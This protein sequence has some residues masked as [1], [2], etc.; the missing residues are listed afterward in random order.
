MLNILEQ[1]RALVGIVSLTL[2]V[3]VKSRNNSM[4]MTNVCSCGWRSPNGNFCVKLLLHSH[5]DIFTKW[6]WWR[7]DVVNSAYLKTGKYY[8]G[9]N[10]SWQSNNAENVFSALFNIYKEGYERQIKTLSD[11]IMHKPRRDSYF[12]NIISMIR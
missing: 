7:T 12:N 10:M 1:K 5:K 3:A 9:K 2:D 6:K 4:G 8:Y 11:V